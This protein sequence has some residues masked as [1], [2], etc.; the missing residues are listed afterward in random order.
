MV[1]WR[2]LCVGWDGDF[3]HTTAETSQGKIGQD[4]LHSEINKSRLLQ[5]Q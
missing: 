3:I 4:P 5:F 1:I 2:R